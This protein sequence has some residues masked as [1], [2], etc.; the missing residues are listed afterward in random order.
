MA[1]EIRT[2]TEEQRQVIEAERTQLMVTASAGAGKTFVLVERYLKLIRQG[3]MPHEILTITFTKKAAAEM[4]RRIVDRLRAEG[5]QDAAQEA[6]T[7]PIQ[8]IHSFCERLLRENSLAAGLDPEFEIMSEGAKARLQ[9]ECVRHILAGNLEEYPEAEALLKTLAGQREYGSVSPYARIEG[10]IARVLRELRGTKVSLGELQEWLR[11]ADLRKRWEQTLLDHTPEEVR[12]ELKKQ[13]NDLGPSERLAAA[14]KAAGLKP[15]AFTKTKTTDRDEQRAAEQTS[16]LLQLAY[17]AWAALES[18]MEQSQSL[19]FSLLEAKAVRLL[20]ESDATRERIKRQYKFVMV[21]EA[22]DVNPVQYALLEQLGL[23]NQLYVGD[24]QQSIYGFRQADVDLFLRRMDELG[25][26]RLSVN[27]RS[28][29]GVLS[30]VDDLFANIWPDR[31]VRMVEQPPFDPEVIELPNYSGVEVWQIPDRNVGQTA[32]FIQEMI[33]EAAIKPGQVTVLTRGSKFANEL[34]QRL[35]ALGQPSR[36]VGGSE[37]FYVRLEIRDLANTLKALGDPYDDFALLATL[38]SPVAGVSLDTIAL[39]A[40]KSPVVEA[41]KDFQPTVEEDIPILEEF[42]TWFLPLKAFADRLSAWEVLSEL[43]ARSGYLA[44]LARR[45][46]GEKMLANV[47]KLLS[48]AAKEPELG[49]IEFANQIREIQRLDHREGDAPAEDEDDRTITIMTIHKAKGLEF[50]TVVL[51]DNYTRLGARAE[52]VEVDPRL[53]LVAAKFNKTNT[54]IHAW[55]NQ[56]RKDREM[57]E[58]M[59]VLYV[60]MTRAKHRLCV[61]AHSST[62]SATCLARTVA[63]AIG[64]GSHPL[65]G[66]IERKI[67]PVPED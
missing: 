32:T 26:L 14:Y 17:S 30:F 10:A 9:D 46:G 37:K 61:A 15:P 12:K 54:L 3:L 13:P 42:K 5:N 52:A 23:E 20:R 27:K 58:E 18:Q 63:K 59:R 44:A 39:L 51:P 36:I 25:S 8:T 4:K 48:L 49:P 41:L 47:R 11:P 55:L 19:D 28:D 34:H 6:E 31:Y 24:A 40:L 57:E 60:A 22:Q 65:P 35:E 43:F 67:G 45:K 7:G 66:V 21:D 62:R 29:K 33:G 2:P 53:G 50:D 64:L 16:G 38:R 1:T 56:V